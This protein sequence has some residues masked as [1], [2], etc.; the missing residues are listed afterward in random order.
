MD[1]IRSR[2]LGLD[3]PRLHGCHRRAGGATRRRNQDAAASAPKTQAKAD[4][5][6]KSS[7]KEAGSS[8]TSASKSTE[9]AKPAPAT[10]AK[11]A[12]SPPAAKPAKTKKK[13]AAAASKTSEIEPRC[14]GPCPHPG[15]DEKA[16]QRSFSGHRAARP[17]IATAK[18][19]TG[20]SFHPGGRQ[21][22]SAFAPGASSSSTSSTVPAACSTTIA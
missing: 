16:A 6:S 8:E 20:M 4:P 22:F 5:D 14:R 10:T 19:M 12:Q 13:A 11:E 2:S 9:P 7:A 21:P 17:M 3:H 15:R 1:A 18:R